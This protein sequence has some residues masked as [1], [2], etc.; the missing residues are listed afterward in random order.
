MVDEKNGVLLQSSYPNEIASAIEKLIM[1]DKN[2]LQQMKLTSKEKVKNNFL[3]G[4]V[5]D[6]TISKIEL[7]IAS[8]K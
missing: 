2:I 5:I 6:E 1:L 3:W 8:K 7:C 4:K